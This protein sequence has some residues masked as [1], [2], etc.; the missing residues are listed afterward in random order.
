MPINPHI[1]G[2][3]YK[4]LS[5]TIKKPLFDPQ[6]ITNGKYTNMQ[7]TKLGLGLNVHTHH[8]S[9]GHLAFTPHCVGCFI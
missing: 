4:G 1:D 5:L 7:V 2:V 6:P 8:I 9:Y 3:S